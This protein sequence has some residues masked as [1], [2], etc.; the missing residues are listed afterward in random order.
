MSGRRFIPRVVWA[1]L[2][3]GFTC[4]DQVEGYTTHEDG[5][6]LATHEKMTRQALDLYLFYTQA[7][8]TP[9]RQEIDA[10]WGRLWWG[11]GDP[12][13]EDPLYGNGGLYVTSI[14]QLWKPDHS[15]GY[16]ATYSI[17]LID[18]YANAFQAAQSLWVRALGYYQAGNKNEAYRYLGMVA[19]LLEDQTVPAYAHGHH[20]EDE[21]FP[22]DQYLSFMGESDSYLLS[23]TERVALEGEGPLLPPPGLGLTGVDDKFL[24]LFLR[25]N[26][27]ADRYA[28]DETDGNY[29]A[30]SDPR[31]AG[32]V[33]DIVSQSVAPWD[34]R[35]EEEPN[36]DRR[37]EILADRAIRKG[38]Y[39]PGIRAVAALF[40]L[41]EEAIS[42]PLLMVT[43][44]SIKE[45]GED[46]FFGT[47]GMD[48]YGKPD[49]Y[50]GMIIGR[51]QNQFPWN[52]S[53]HGYA[54]YLENRED[55]LRNINGAPLPANITRADAYKDVADGGTEDATVVYPNYRFG[56]SYPIPAGGYLVGQDIVMAKLSVWENDE[57]ADASQYPYTSDDPADIG[58]GTGVP[59]TIFA[60][61]AKCAAGDADAV[62][63]GAQSYA[64]GELITRTGVG[65]NDND[66]KVVF[67][68]R[69]GKF[70]LVTNTNNTG[71]G[72]LRNIIGDANSLVRFAPGLS[73]QTI[74]ITTGD[75]TVPSAP[76]TIKGSGL[77]D[78]I[79]ITASQPTRIG[80]AEE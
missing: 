28:C 17:G 69:L 30:P 67:S 80:P 4:S 77:A 45:I 13:R 62:T 44:H 40:A 46:A 35:A 64:S 63:V 74:T 6:D 47:Y 9:I 70:G 36:A 10:H 56:Q 52:T 37:I 38:S 79:K 16:P 25:T 22:D 55:E 8:A 61:L 34:T 65:D 19:H 68:V 11:A 50:V 7:T 73:G 20:E 15:L 24:W 42:I 18:N 27:I 60:D 39:V 23:T 49:F 33:Q 1:I 41:W 29:T 48:G 54:P 76:I 59:I 5:P 3:A 12:N 21:D 32:W 58:L 31:V 51:N 2:L 14:T 71:G 57:T 43:V 75:I 53:S 66:V 26:Q 78:K 72:S